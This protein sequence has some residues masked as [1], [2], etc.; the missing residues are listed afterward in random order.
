MKTTTLLRVWLVATMALLVVSPILAS[1]VAGKWKAEFQ[2][3]DG[4]TRT[5]VFTFEVKGEALTGTVHSSISNQDASIQEGTV[6]GDDISFFVVRSFDGNEI[7][8]TYAGKI[9]GDSINFTV[10]ASGGGQ[11]FEFPMVAKREK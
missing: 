9:A 3:P 1:D 8:L 11:S 7:K 4:A 10:T 6:K 2:S 5:N